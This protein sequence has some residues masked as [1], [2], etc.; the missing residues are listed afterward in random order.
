M[1]DLATSRAGFEDEAGTFVKRKRSTITDRRRPSNSG[2]SSQKSARLLFREGAC[3][4][5]QN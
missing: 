5:D 4:Y 2:L 3:A 1:S